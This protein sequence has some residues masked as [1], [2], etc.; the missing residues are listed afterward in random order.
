MADQELQEIAHTGGKVTFD[1]QV[2]ADGRISYSVK[3]SHSRPTPAGVFAVYAI[4]HGIA[5]GDIRIA[6]M[7]VPWNPPPVPGSYEQSRGSLTAHI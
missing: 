3:W 6:G 5:V 7:G 2:D 1:V 4:P